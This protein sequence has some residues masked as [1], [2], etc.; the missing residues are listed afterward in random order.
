MKIE[1]KVNKADLKDWLEKR[2]INGFMILFSWP[3]KPDSP[4]NLS[5]ERIMIQTDKGHFFTLAEVEKEIGKPVFT[6]VTV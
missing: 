4:W 1:V 3:I 2:K 6:V 5:K